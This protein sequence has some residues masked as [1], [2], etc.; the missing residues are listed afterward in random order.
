MDNK[1][2]DDL[3]ISGYLYIP[4]QSFL[5]LK[6]SWSKK[7]F[8]LYKRSSSGIQRLELFDSQESHLKKSNTLIKIIALNECHK[9]SIT[10]H[11]QQSNVFE[12]R[13]RE[14]VH[15][16][17]AET[18]QQ[19]QLWLE[20]LRSVAF[21]IDNNSPSRAISN[22]PAKSPG[23]I[24]CKSIPEAVTVTV[25]GPNKD[26]PLTNC[27]NHHHPRL[28][29]D[30]SINHVCVLTANSNNQSIP[31]Q[32]ENMLY[33]SVDA[34]DLY[35]VKLV[36]S[37]ATIR[38]KLAATDYYLVLTSVSISLAE[39][40]P[41]TRQGKILW[42]WPYRHIRRYG[43]TKDGFSLEAG[44]KC[45]TGEGLFSFITSD[46]SAIFKCVASHVTSLKTTSPNGVFPVPRSSPIELSATSS[47]VPAST[48][49]TTSSSSCS[50]VMSTNE[51]TEVSN[52][53]QSNP[54]QQ[55]FSPNKVTFDGQTANSNINAV[56]SL[57][58]QSTS[59]S[60]L[61]MPK[62]NP[63]QQTNATS[64]SI[65]T[66][67]ANG[68][69]DKTVTNSTT[70]SQSEQLSTVSNTNFRHYQRPSSPKPPT[71]PRGARPNQRESANQNG[72]TFGTNHSTNGKQNPKP[73]NHYNNQI[74]Q[75][76]MNE[77]SFE[78][79]KM[80]KPNE[81][82]SNSLQAKKEAN[83]M[84]TLNPMDS[85]TI[86]P[87]ENGLIIISDEMRNGQSIIKPP[88]RGRFNCD[89]KQLTFNLSDG[90]IETL[91]IPVT[92][93]DPLYED[94]IFVSREELFGL[95]AED[96]EENHYEIPVIVNGNVNNDNDSSTHNYEQVT[97]TNNGLIEIG[98]DRKIISTVDGKTVNEK[99][100]RIHPQV[101]RLT[102]VIRSM[103]TGNLGNIVNSRKSVKLEKFSQSSSSSEGSY[104][105]LS[106]GPTVSGS[107]SFEVNKQ[108]SGSESSN[109]S[110]Y[111]EICD[112]P[113]SNSLDDKVD[114]VNQK[115][116]HHLINI[117]S[118]RKDNKVHGNDS[119]N[120]NGCLSIVKNC[121]TTD[122]DEGD[123][124]NLMPEDSVK[125]TI[126][127]NKASRIVINGSSN[128]KCSP[129]PDHYIQNDAEYALIMKRS[130]SCDKL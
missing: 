59:S 15:L 36:I 85:V 89:G 26:K 65:L 99:L 25:N 40:L 112:L 62:S 84:V 119:N 120:S 103:F 12:I 22:T 91:A 52:C 48:T 29:K 121:I 130:I 100:P 101:S 71:L 125:S 53:K 115:A 41:D 7:Y 123:Y 107:I 109:E 118:N 124:V 90:S 60:S 11:K 68:S 39:K 117:Y 122:L 102:S 82:L 10:T 45:L 81:A 35:N 3:V 70:S 126:S 66:V 127:N 31:Q 44:R 86:L 23:V 113:E 32:E 27:H 88:R 114:Y 34:P 69:P 98:Y 94:P 108:E 111:S 21:A 106:S 9:V 28:D 74:A 104:S 17:S 13:T 92:I 75:P 116:K 78:T 57:P 6:Q 96:K 16:F 63:S 80:V 93:V 18:Y 1:D 73:N 19:M 47:S 30:A 33:S 5:K 110:P 83:S 51:K 105:S 43:C 14:A 2:S 37:E 50:T 72:V 4:S 64:G 8:A 49:V 38:C 46:G 55:T 76:K 61:S 79:H 54:C 77:L 129:N 67:A 56:T 58:T 128:D 20:A 95:K 97:I 87:Q 24:N 42:T